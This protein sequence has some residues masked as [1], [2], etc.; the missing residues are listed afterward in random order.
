MSK[1]RSDTRGGKEIIGT[2][3]LK[4]NSGLIKPKNLEVAII[5][6]GISGLS[7][8]LLLEQLGCNVIIYE[9]DRYIKSEGAGIQVTSNGLFVLKKLDLD[10]LVVEAGL[11]PG[12]L[13]LLDENDFKSI[14]CLEIRDRLK[15]R[16]GQSFLTLHRSLL[17]EI[18]FE[19]VKEKK[20][21]V[22]FGS[23]A[24][25]LVKKDDED[26]YIS[27]KGKKIE[28]DLIVVADG[29]G[30]SWKSTIFR[31]NKTRNISQSAYRFVLN[32]KNLPPIF[33][34]NNINLFFGRGRHFVTYPTGKNGM[35]NFVFCK[36]ESGKMVNHWKEKVAKQ[37]FLNDFEL[38]DSLKICIPDVK[39][40][41]RWPV[42]ESGI[43]VTI[44]K[45]NVVMVGDA[46]HGMLPY[47]AQGAN[48]ALED[49]FELAKCVGE[50]PLDLKKGLI[51]YSKKRIKRI[52]QLDR[53][54]RFNEKA[55]H[56]EQKMLRK[57]FFLFLRSVTSLFP[58]FFFKRFDW[59]YRYKG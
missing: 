9:K 59:I 54:S 11:K 12:K 41:Y 30:S 2:I 27:C 24:L 3:R 15:R 32:N 6:A 29:I 47:M 28:K 31:E 39:K 5:G 18:L 14:G 43:P 55:Y 17:I 19:R 51:K 8:A 7:A 57:I 56:L 10:S 25:P 4:E 20:I 58:N 23:R 53:V 45:K 40:I 46:A 38:N 44:Q 37:K 36:R 26:I 21:R 52:Y 48:K 22:N 34:E 50:F 49:S 42:I 33:L 16:Y 13:C 1:L 35:I